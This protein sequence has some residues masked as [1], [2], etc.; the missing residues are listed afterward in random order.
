MILVLL[1]STLF[2]QGGAA[3]AAAPA[4]AIPWAKTPSAADVAAA[5]PAGPKS[6]NM[7]GSGVISCTVGTAGELTGCTAESES[8]AGAGFG[9]AAVGLAGKFQVGVGKPGGAA[10]VG[11]KVTVP[12]RWLNDYK[13]KADPIIVYD[14]AGRSGVIAFNCRVRGDRGVDNCVVVDAHPR[15]SSALFGV[16]GEATLRQK[17]PKN[18]AVGDRVAIVVEVKPVS[19]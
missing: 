8:P 4:E 7:A 5:Y 17:A 12:V 6:E 1:A 13:A 10:W 16:A 15:G 11:R 18:G 3:R 19:R 14:D 2:L 9:A